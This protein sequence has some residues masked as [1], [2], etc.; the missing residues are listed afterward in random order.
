MGARRWERPRAYCL[1]EHHGNARAHITELTEE[2]MTTAAAAGASRLIA[3]LEGHGFTRKDRGS[4]ALLHER[5][6]RLSRFGIVDAVVGVSVAPMATAESLRELDVATKDGAL[7]L[8]TRFPRGLISAV[9]IFPVLFADAADDSAI[10]AARS[11]PPNRWAIMTTHALLHGEDHQLERHEGSKIWG[12]AY[13]KG[14]R[15]RLADWL[16]EA[17]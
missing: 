7:D 8:K 10:R 13:V 14:L 16:L 3:V 1:R 9:E 5:K 2:A 17:L 6:F 15:Q 11:T 4:V 12:G